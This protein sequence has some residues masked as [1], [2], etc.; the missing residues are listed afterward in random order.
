MRGCALVLRNTRR[1]HLHALCGVRHAAAVAV[2]HGGGARA[3][4]LGGIRTVESLW[5]R[6]RRDLRVGWTL[7]PRGARRVAARIAAAGADPRPRL[8]VGR[9]VPAAARRQLRLSRDRLRIGEPRLLPRAVAERAS[10][11]ARGSGGRE[12]T[13][14]GGAAARRVRALARSRADAGTGRGAAEAGGHADRA[15][16]DR[17][18]LHA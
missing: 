6:G 4:V 8:R 5:R 2:P 3:R 18:A 12:R 15:D 9:D 14:L 1:L 13:V 11:H 16:A 7:L 17:A 10:W